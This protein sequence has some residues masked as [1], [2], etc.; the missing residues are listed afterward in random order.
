M[1][2][3]VQ[4]SCIR[5]VKWSLLLTNTYCG[6]PMTMMCSSIESTIHPTIHLAELQHTNS[7]LSTLGEIDVKVALAETIADYVMAEL[8]QASFLNAPRWY[9]EADLESHKEVDIGHD[10]MLFEIELTCRRESVR[11]SSTFSTTSRKKCDYAVV[12]GPL[13]SCSGPRSRR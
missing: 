10:L 2:N 11:Q 9:G 5:A 6:Q 1:L 8:H 4:S 7:V 12:E 3:A 13:L